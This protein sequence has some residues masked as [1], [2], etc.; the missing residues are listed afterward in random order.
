M[1]DDPKL[2]EARELIDAF[3]KELLAL[4]DGKA[5]PP[6]WTSHL[7]KALGPKRLG[8]PVNNAIQQRN[9]YIAAEVIRLEIAGRPVTDNAKGEGAFAEV[10]ARHSLSESEV[11]DI[12]YEYL[13][14]GMSQILLE[15][16]RKPDS[17]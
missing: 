4:N 11:R 15:R 14:D 5:L 16:L 9:V 13:N 12:Y 1:S 10:A 2:D 6:T 3:A 17:A 8:R 7:L